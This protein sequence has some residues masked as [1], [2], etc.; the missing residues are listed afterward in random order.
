MRTCAMKGY[1]G[2]IIR[3]LLIRPGRLFD[4]S[5]FRQGVKIKAKL[6]VFSNEFI[7]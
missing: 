3:I 4:F 5:I 2:I 1:L 7:T 6:F